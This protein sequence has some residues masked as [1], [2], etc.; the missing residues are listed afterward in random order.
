MGDLHLQPP[1]LHTASFPYLFSH[2][3]PDFGGLAGAHEGFVDPRVCPWC[4]LS[5]VSGDAAA[6][7]VNQLRGTNGAWRQKAQGDT[8]GL[9]WY[10][11]MPG[12][13]KAQD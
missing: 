4:R 2:K 12:V 6:L 8:S 3:L 11:A 9:T 13:P 10:T 1:S 5:V 7:G